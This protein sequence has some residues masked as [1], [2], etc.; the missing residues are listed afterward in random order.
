P[1]HVLVLGGAYVGLEF[2]QMFRRFGSRVTI[3]QRA[4]QLLGRE[5]QDVADDV[6]GIMRED[7]VEVLLNTEAA[8]VEKGRGGEIHLTV[9]TPEGERT[10]TGSH[11]LAAAG[12][13]PNPATVNL[14]S[15]RIETDKHGFIQANDRLET[16]PPGRYAAAD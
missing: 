13:T 3:V 8:R 11:L 16:S 9:R 5:D 12:R 6:A 14:S 4:Q 7:G 10:L 2:G 1:E 15:A